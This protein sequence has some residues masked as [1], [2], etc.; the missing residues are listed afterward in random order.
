M[1]SRDL[2]RY[3]DRKYSLGFKFRVQ[4]S[5]LRSFVSFAEKCGDK[6]VK[7]AR[8][9]TWAALAP[10]PEQRRNR[11]LTVRRF[12]LT[13]HAEDQCHQI[14]AADAF[15]NAVGKRRSA[16]IYTPEEIKRLLRA[17]AELEPA[18]SIRPTMYVT[19]LGLLTATGMR[20]AEALA[21]QLDDATDDGLVVR[22]TKFHK[23]RLLPLHVTVQR[24]LDKYLMVRRTLAC[25]DRA[26][27]LS[28][29]G[30]PL[31]YS[32]VRYVFLHLLGRTG[33]KGAHSGRD[34]RIHDLRHTFAIRSL[35]QCHHKQDAVPRHIVALSTY[36]GHAHVTDTYWYPQATPFLLGQIAEAGEALLKG[37]AV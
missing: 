29:G 28:S 34:P 32:T 17:A 10:S 30:Q 36:L 31:S 4:H 1:L 11:L 20:I 6:H 12:A 27:F 25:T 26:L 21:L 16:Y 15:G 13:M 35:E 33:M 24:A 19:L 22:E 9:L 5:L 8:V 23:S 37:G 2:A 14:P 7:S 18:G 3:V